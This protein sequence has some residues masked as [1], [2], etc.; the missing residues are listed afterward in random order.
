MTKTPPQK[1]GLLL[2]VLAV[3]IG[4][5][6]LFLLKALTQPNLATPS[7]TL[8]TTATANTNPLAYPHAQLISQIQKDQVTNLEWQTADPIPT[9]VD[10]YLSALV[11]LGWEVNV[12]PA[13]LDAPDIQYLTALKNSSLLQ[14][15][16]IRSSPTY[17]TQ[18]ILV[19]QP[20]SESE[21]GEE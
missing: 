11:S 9:V 20:F 19:I 15:S 8:N 2:I 3:I 10:W 21:P 13:N 16:L 18:I 12:F 6:L 17:P 14:L 7:Q 4:L 1:P 5:A